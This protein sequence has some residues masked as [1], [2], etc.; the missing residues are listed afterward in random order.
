[1]SAAGAASSRSC[2]SAPAGDPEARLIGVVADDGRVGYVRPALRVP[3]QF[4]ELVRRPADAARFR[5]A[6]PCVEGRC[7]NWTGSRCGVID[8]LA[9]AEPGVPAGDQRLPRCAIRPTCV[10]FSQRGARACV[11]CPTVHSDDLLPE[12]FAAQAE[13]GP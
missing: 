10:W 13:G 3:P 5:F 2:P 11:I 7:A 1:M 9:A 6:A 8:A 4:V 12:P